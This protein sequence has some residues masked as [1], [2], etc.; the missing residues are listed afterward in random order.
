MATSKKRHLTDEDI[1]ET[2]SNSGSNLSS[3]DELLTAFDYVTI[4][5]GDE[6]LPRERPWHCGK[7]NP[8]IPQFVGEPGIQN[9][10]SLV[11]RTPLDYFQ[12]FFDETIMKR[13][14]DETNRY[15]L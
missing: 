9:T 1:E 5:S 6:D 4:D 10:I 13:I 12:L 8:T 7:F 14:V 11:A 2:M 3:E 15:Y